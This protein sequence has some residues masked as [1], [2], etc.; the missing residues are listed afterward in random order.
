[1]TSRLER[2]SPKAVEAIRAAA[3]PLE[4]ETSDLDPLVERL[5]AAR[6]VLLGEST[7]GTHEIYRERARI[8][9]RLVEEK[10][11]RAVAIEGDWPDA[12]RVNRFVRGHGDDR[13]PLD[14]LGDFGRFPRWMWRNA[15]ALDLV[16]WLRSWNEGKP[17]TRRVGFYGL[18]LYALHGS[19]EALLRYLDE[20]DPGAAKRARERYSCFERFGD[21]PQRYGYAT[22]HGHAEPC[23][24]AALRQLVEMQQRRGELLARDGRF[25]PDEHF[26]ALQSSRLVADAEGYYRAMF[27]G[28]VESW[29]LR[30]QHMIETLAALADHLATTGPAPVRIVVWAHNSHVGDAR[31]TEMGECGEWNLG[32]LARRRFGD[33]AALVGFTTHHGTVTAAHDWDGPALRRALRPAI[34]GSYESLF[35]AVEVPRFLLFPRPDAH[36][37]LPVGPLLERAVGVVYRPETERASHYFESHLAKQFDAI[38]HLDETRAVVPLDPSPEWETLHPGDAET[39]SASSR[40]MRHGGAS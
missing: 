17:E 8:T 1:V 19:I 38:V 39:D 29:N 21:D 6:F 15:D 31:A 14:A 32:E 37:A 22:S 12:F 3:R 40:S 27:R 25:A 13:E 11:F 18:D 34:E 9:Q 30:D 16:A 4:G 2:A 36:P 26:H 5:G 24:D 28:Q 23:E 7:H 20:V 10:G 35:H 33:D